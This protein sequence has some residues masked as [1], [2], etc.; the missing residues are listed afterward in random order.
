[1]KIKPAGGLRESVGRRHGGQRRF[2]LS[3]E[4]VSGVRSSSTR[5]T[6]MRRGA[7]RKSEANSLL[8]DAASSRNE[9]KVRYVLTSMERGTKFEAGERR[10]CSAAGEGQRKEV[11]GFRERHWD[12]PGGVAADWAWRGCVKA[13]ERRWRGRAGQGS[14]ADGVIGSCRKGWGREEFGSFYDHRGGKTMSWGSPDVRYRFVQ[15]HSACEQ[16]FV[17]E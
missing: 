16:L 12:P 8:V 3:S 7:R 10:C 17:L 5:I 11:K 4:S 9:W 14:T 6:A 15:S 2:I 1:V 13:V